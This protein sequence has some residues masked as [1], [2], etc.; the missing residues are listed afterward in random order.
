MSVLRYWRR[1]HSTTYSEVALCRLPSSQPFTNLVRDLMFPS[2]QPR[3]WTI[4]YSLFL[5]LDRHGELVP[6]TEYLVAIALE[7]S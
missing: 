4:L 1:E 2:S 3:D 6:R 7:L 5:E